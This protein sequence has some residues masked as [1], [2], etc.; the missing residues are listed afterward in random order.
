MVVKNVYQSYHLDFHGMIGYDNM[1]LYV[2]SISRSVTAIGQGAF[3]SKF[4]STSSDIE[5]CRCT[6]ERVGCY[7]WP[8]NY[9]RFVS[10]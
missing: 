9:H 1:T 2:V 8:Y 5:R 3:D 4:R 10:F 6:V 7:D